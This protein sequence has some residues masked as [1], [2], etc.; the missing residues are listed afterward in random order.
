MIGGE[1]AHDSGYGVATFRITGLFCKRAPPPHHK[2]W[3]SFAKETCN[4]INLM[5]GGELSHDSGY[6]VARFSRI[7]KITGL[8]CKRA[9]Q[10][11][12]YSAKETYNFI[13]P[14]YRSHP[15]AVY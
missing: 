13:D 6:G 12:R 10:K 1:P 3:G 9:P 11:R 2:W 7:D 4:K 5:I 14:T 8:F 15:I